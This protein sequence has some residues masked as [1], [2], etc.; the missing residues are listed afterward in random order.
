MIVELENKKILFIHIPKC[1]GTSIEKSL[2]EQKGETYP[3]KSWLIND[4]DKL[5]GHNPELPIKLR[6]LNHLTCYNIFKELNIKND[7]DYIFTICR[8]P[9]DR[10]VSLANWIRDGW[11]NENCEWNSNEKILINFKNLQELVEH[12]IYKCKEYPM[13]IPQYKYIEGY[14]EIV[15]IFK[16]EDGMDNIMKKIENDN[17]FSFKFN[18]INTNYPS[19]KHFRVEHIDKKTKDLIN[20]FYKKDFEFFQY[21]IENV[22]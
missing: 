2:Y 19:K 21:T 22:V 8:N 13:F 18:R 17:N 9:Y 4:F 7:L 16:L 6:K 11:E 5:Y 12:I 15:K 20:D 3:A 14:D 1:A 10:F